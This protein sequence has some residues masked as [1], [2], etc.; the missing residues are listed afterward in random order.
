MLVAGPAF[1]QIPG[2]GVKGGVNLATQRNSGDEG[3]SDDIKSLVG[4]VGGAFAT[5]HLVSFLEVQPE[6]LYSIKGARADFE[7]IASKL[8][9]DY[10]EVP[11]LLRVSKRGG[12]G[13]YAAGGPSVAFQ[14]RARTRTKFAGSTEEIDIS[15]QVE[16][17]DF[18][19]AIGGG[20]EIGSLVFDGRYTHG[21]YDV[22]KDKSD[23]VKVTNRALSF[24]AGFRF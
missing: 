10:L 5:F 6:V 14:M 20:V 11:L 8:L 21:L 24:T 15:D 3:N 9:I 18:G 19:M 12:I 1:A 2:L 13:Y 16:R 22:D 17:L 7:G 23:S 4:F